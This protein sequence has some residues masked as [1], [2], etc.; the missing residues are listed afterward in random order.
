MLYRQLESLKEYIVI[1]SLEMRLEKFSKVAVNEW[2][3]KEYIPPEDFIT[4]DAIGYQTS[5]AQ[6]YRDVVFEEKDLSR[7]AVGR[8]Y[9]TQFVF[10]KIGKLLPQEGWQRIPR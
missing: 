4:I 1:S 8:E 2:S 10:A 6:C 7:G 5:L 3:L 9:P